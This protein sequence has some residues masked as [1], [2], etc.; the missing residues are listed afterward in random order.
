MQISLMLLCC[1]LSSV[2]AAGEFEVG[3]LSMPPC[4][5]VEYRQQTIFPGVKIGVPEARIAPQTVRVSA[6]VEG[7][8]VDSP[9]NA[10]VMRTCVASASELGVSV[11]AADTAGAAAIFKDRLMSCLKTRAPSVRVDVAFL[12][13]ESRC[14]W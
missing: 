9:N 8:G 11:M 13:S 14:E 12:K 7:S 2:C 5:K 6:V 1:L 3:R 10:E 4:S